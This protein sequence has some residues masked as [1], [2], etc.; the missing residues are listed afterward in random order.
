MAQTMQRPP[1]RF[2]FSFHRWY[3]FIFLGTTGQRVISKDSRKVTLDTPQAVETLEYLLGLSRAGVI[4]PDGANELYRQA[5]NDI[6]FESQGP[7]RIPTLRQV[8]APDFG[9]THLPVHR[10]KKEI[11]TEA[12][13]HSLVVFRE[14]P[15]ERRT[16]AALVAQWLNAPHAQARL[17]IV[18]QAI[19]VSKATMND[20]ELKDFLKTDEQFASFVEI[21]P[22][23]WRWPNV[24]S[25]DMQRTTIA[26]GIDPVF[27]EQIG[28]K[29]WLAE[30]EHKAQALLDVDVAKMK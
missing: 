26:R 28:I 24:P 5:T 20:K 10:V 12:G 17:C 15:P 18:S 22:Y 9:A 7:Y 30:T 27:N 29:A 19:P 8:N 13:G 2:A 14:S 4:P 16:A 3:W 23:A 11:F 6:A 1:V 25:S 21:A